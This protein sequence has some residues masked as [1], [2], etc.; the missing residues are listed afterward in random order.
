VK[1]ETTRPKHL[2]PAELA[3]RI[4]VTVH[5]SLLEPS[6]ALIGGARRDRAG[7]LE[8]HPDRLTRLELP[9]SATGFGLRWVD[10]PTA[11]DAARAAERARGVVLACATAEDAYAS[12]CRW[13]DAE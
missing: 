5:P 7:R 12:L 4:R 10:Y 3:D 11:D 1:T 9:G 6:M 8:W 13:Y 2:T